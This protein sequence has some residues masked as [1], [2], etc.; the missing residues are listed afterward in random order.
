M[1]YLKKVFT[2]K[3]DLESVFCR[4][5][6]VGIP[7]STALSFFLSLLFPILGLFLFVYWI[8]API[9]LLINIGNTDKLALKII[10]VIFSSFWIVFSFI[11]F[12]HV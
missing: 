8:I 6:M 11:F 5:I 4:F 10:V 9:L 3:A 7:L 1:N 2:G 12:F